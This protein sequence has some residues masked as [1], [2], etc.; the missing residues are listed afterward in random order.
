MEPTYDISKKFWIEYEDGEIIAV[1]INE[2][3]DDESTKAI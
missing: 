3:N 2:E 1:A